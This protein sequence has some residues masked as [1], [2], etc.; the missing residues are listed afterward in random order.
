MIQ[1]LRHLYDIL[2]TYEAKEQVYLHIGDEMVA[3][4]TGLRKRLEEIDGD[5]FEVDFCRLAKKYLFEM[6]LPRDNVTSSFNRH[7]WPDL[8]DPSVTA[9]VLPKPVCL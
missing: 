9:G 5:D 6:D 1:K 7:D 3:R 2:G 8:D 4:L